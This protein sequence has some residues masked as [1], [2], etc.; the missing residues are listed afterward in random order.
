M[1]IVDHDRFRSLPTP[2]RAVFVTA[3]ALADSA[4]YVADRSMIAKAVGLTVPH[5]RR[6][7]AHLEGRRWMNRPLLRRIGARELWVLMVDIPGVPRRPRSETIAPEVSAP[8]LVQRWRRDRG[9]ARKEADA[10]YPGGVADPEFRWLRARVGGLER[11]VKTMKQE[12]DEARR[13][14]DRLD[15]AKTATPPAAKAL[16]DDLEH[17]SNCGDPD[18]SNCIRIA[19]QLEDP[20]GPYIGVTRGW[21]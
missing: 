17:A 8:P 1:E 18:C 14:L 11:S 9:R 7:F 10:R 3:R 20:D 21:L 13:L 4:G 15:M 16:R 19:E 12:R 2:A 5:V 6:W